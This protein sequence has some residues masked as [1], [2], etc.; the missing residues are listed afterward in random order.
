MFKQFRCK[1]RERWVKL[2]AWFDD[3]ETKFLAFVEGSGGAIVAGLAAVDP[4]M[5]LSMGMDRKQAIVLGL[6]LFA[7]GVISYR[8]RDYREDD[9]PDA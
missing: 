9:K 2:M 7:K 5:F 1:V 8:V 3:K 4:S 6:F